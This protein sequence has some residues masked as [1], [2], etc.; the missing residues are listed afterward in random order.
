[1]ECR[2]IRFSAHAIRQMHEREIATN[3]V[4]SVLEEG[5]VI[6][7][8][9]NDNPFPSRLLLGYAEGRPLHVVVAKDAESGKCFV[10]TAY[11]P[12]PERWTPDFRKRRTKL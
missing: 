8:Y 9:P 6:E 12:D 10:V 1:M 2:E 4:L 7:D 11:E 5:E 3:D